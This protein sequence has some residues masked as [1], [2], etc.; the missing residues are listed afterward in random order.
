MTG[1]DWLPGRTHILNI[2]AQKGLSQGHHVLWFSVTAWL[3]WLILLSLE[4]PPHDPG[5]V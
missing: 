5:L 4:S 2:Q 1:S 3:L